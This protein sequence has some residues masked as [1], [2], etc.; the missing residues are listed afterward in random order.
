AHILDAAGDQIALDM[1]RLTFDGRAIPLADATPEAIEM[2]LAVAGHEIKITAV[3]IGNPH[4]VVFVEAA[5]A[6][7]EG[8]ART[9][10]PHLERHPLFPNRTNVQ[11]VQ[12]LSQHELRMAIWERGAGY[13]LASGTSSCAAAGAAIRAGRC[14]SPITVHMPGGSARVEISADWEAR[15]IGPVTPVCRGEVAADVIAA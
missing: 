15:L 10:G 11:F 1:G 8:L 5:D 4:C 6:D 12:V 7:L 2:P 14:A 13:T 3:G 9:L